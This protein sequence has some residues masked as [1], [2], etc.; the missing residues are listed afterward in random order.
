MTTLDACRAAMLCNV[1]ALWSV[2]KYAGSFGGTAVRAC[3]RAYANIEAINADEN[4]SQ[5]FMSTAKNI[6]LA[7]A[8]RTPIGRYGGA[9][10]GL[11]SAELGAI[12]A[13]ESLRRAG[14][15]P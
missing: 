5:I 13:R 9:L 8:V 3:R 10:A 14:L 1:C 11:T 2:R 6:Y 7:G 15:E 12:V 4:H